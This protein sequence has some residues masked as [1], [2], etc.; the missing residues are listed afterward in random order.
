MKVMLECPKLT[1][2]QKE[3]V[4]S[5]FLKYFPIETDPSI[6]SSEKQQA[7]MDWW[8]ANLEI[9]STLSLNLA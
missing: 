5:D 7:M 9:F 6:P 3:K 1:S 8:V 4:K 2:E